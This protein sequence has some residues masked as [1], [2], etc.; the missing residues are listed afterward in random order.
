MMAMFFTASKDVT[1][2]KLAIMVEEWRAKNETGLQY[3][4]KKFKQDYTLQ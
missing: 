3:Y 1:K 4:W 2:E